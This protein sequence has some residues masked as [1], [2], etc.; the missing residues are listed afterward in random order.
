VIV[1]DDHQN[2]VVGQG[3]YTI[4][5]IGFKGKKGSNYTVLFENKG[6]IP[7]LISMV[8]ASPIPLSMNVTTK[9]DMAATQQRVERI[10]NEF[11]VPLLLR[12]P[13]RPS[14]KEIS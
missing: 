11:K 3:F 4:T 2:I 12:R 7:K 14:R 8:L 5:G 9:E 10:G 6:A 1:Y 13:Y